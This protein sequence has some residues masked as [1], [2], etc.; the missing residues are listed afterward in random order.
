MKGISNMEKQIKFLN[1]QYLETRLREIKEI[2]RKEIFFDI[3]ESD[4][5]FSKSIYVN[6]YIENADGRKFKNHTLRISDHSLTDCPHSQFI[7]EPNDFL[8]KKKKAQFIKAIENSVKK[9]QTRHL[10]K[11]IDKIS[12]ENK[13]NE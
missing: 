8:T 11:I 3:E 13:N 1:K 2:K 4:R 12:K 6:F 10:Y 7:I 5:T 9:A